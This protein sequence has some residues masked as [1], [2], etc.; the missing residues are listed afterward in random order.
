MMKRVVR[1]KK[2][3]GRANAMKKRGGGFIWW[4]WAFSRVGSN[5]P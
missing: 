3:L 5:T 4:T 1:F 2:E